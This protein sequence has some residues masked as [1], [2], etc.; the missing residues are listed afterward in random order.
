MVLDSVVEPVDLAVLLA[1]IDAGNDARA[2]VRVALAVVLL[3]GIEPVDL[4]RLIGGGDAGDDPR[5]PFGLSWPWC[6]FGASNR[7]ISCG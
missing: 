6:C 7:S 5:A 3:R 1:L 2:R 4:V